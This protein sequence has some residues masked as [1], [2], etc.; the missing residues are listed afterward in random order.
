[1]KKNSY[2][3]GSILVV[4]LIFTLYFNHK[5][6]EKNLYEISIELEKYNEK[7]YKS[8]TPNEKNLYVKVYNDLVLQYNNEYKKFPNILIYKFQN[9]YKEVEYWQYNKNHQ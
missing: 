9:K 5:K 3:I 6:S 2:I 7:I 1:M 8:E 4:F